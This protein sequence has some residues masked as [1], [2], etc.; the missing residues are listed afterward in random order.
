MKETAMVDLKMT[1][2]YHRPWRTWVAYYV[3]DAGDQ[4]GEAGYGSSRKAA[5]ADVAYQFKIATKKYYD[6][7]D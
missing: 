2:Y 4:V 5:A 7:M 6:R 1:V 3:T